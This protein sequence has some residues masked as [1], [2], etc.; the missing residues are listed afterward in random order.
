MDIACKNRCSGREYT[1]GKISRP[2]G[3]LLMDCK[4]LSVTAAECKEGGKDA[5]YRMVNR[6]EVPIV[7]D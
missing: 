2:V 4:S 6:W 3:S 1:E 5:P 7:S